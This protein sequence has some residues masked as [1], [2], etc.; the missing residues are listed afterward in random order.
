MKK[1]YSP[2]LPFAGFVLLAATVLQAEEP[3]ASPS[4]PARHR[5]HRDDMRENFR[6][7]AK[8]LDLTADQ[9]IQMEAIRKQ[10]G[11][12]LKALH[13]DASLTDDQKRDKVRELRKSNEEQI[14]ALLT[15]EQ[16]TKA[17]AFRENNGHRRG[18]AGRQGAASTDA[19]PA[20]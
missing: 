2:L 11:E 19:S 17:R 16:K 13:A 1:R 18:K 15:P 6:K 10:T 8:E 3:A 12:S 4:P 9:K 7:M 5:E 20:I 14:R